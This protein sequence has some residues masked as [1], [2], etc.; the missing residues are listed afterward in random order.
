MAAI[1]NFHSFNSSLS[2][3]EREGLKDLITQHQAELLAARSEDARTRITE[4]YI[5]EVHDILKKT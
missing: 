3:E 2:K 4:H 1:D 5:K